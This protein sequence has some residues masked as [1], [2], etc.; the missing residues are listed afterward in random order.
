MSGLGVQLYPGDMDGYL[1]HCA[2]ENA[3]DR[4]D[5]AARERARAQ[6][7]QHGLTLLQRCQDCEAD[8]SCELCGDPVGPGGTD[9][10]DECEE[11]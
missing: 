6:R 4:A 3:R 11:R 9:L 5:E 8:V 2:E 7:C 10:C 1:R